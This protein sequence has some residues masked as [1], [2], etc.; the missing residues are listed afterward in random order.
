MK[1]LLPRFAALALCVFPMFGQAEPLHVAVSVKPLHSIVA[2]IM[3]GTGSAPSL[4]VTGGNSPHGFQL[5]PSQLQAIAH[6][7][8]LFYMADTFEPFLRPAI[9][10]AQEGALIVAVGEKAPVRLLPLREGGLWEPDEDEEHGEAAQD[11]HLWLSPANGAVMAQ[12][13]AETLAAR[14][15]A[16]KETYL[17]NARDLRARLMQLDGEIRAATAPA[18][19]KPY[20]VFHDAYHY[21]EERYGL[22][23]AGSITVEPD[24]PVSAKR[25]GALRQKIRQT[26]A[27]C[28]FREPQFPSPL[29]ETVVEGTMARTALLDPE[30]SSITPGPE[31]YEALLRQVTQQFLRCLS[32]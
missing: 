11:Y 6:T 23:P 32:E 29:T 14:D 19:G 24:Q 21:Y 28:V 4:I 2:S 31:L 7:D 18:K 5:K 10:Q 8:V 22:T 30:G 15:P 12:F 3:A 25:I 13:V 27:R 20:I 16:H 1:R 26:Q 17:A 9:A